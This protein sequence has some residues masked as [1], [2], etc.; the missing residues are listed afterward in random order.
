MSDRLH[1]LL[2]S[3]WYPSAE[4][5]VDGLFVRD[6]ARAASLFCDVTVLL[7]SGSA[8]DS[9]DAGL[10]V[11]R[12]LPDG[13]GILANF[14]R[15]LAI[16]ATVR[17][18]RQEGH[19]PDIIHGHVY[20]AAFVAVLVGRLQGLPVVVSEHHTDFVE[21]RLSRR[22]RIIARITFRSAKLVCP[23]SRALMQSM[24]ELE[25]NG[26]YSVVPNTVDVATFAAGMRLRPAAVDDP[27][28][29]N[30][31]GLSARRKGLLHL[32]EALRILL[33]RYPNACLKLAG[34]GPD[35]DELESAAEGLPVVFLGACSRDELVEL[36]READVLVMASTAETFGIAPLESLA[37]GL[38]VVATTAFP[39]ADLIAELGGQIVRPGDPSA[40]SEAITSV[41][42][43]RSFVRSDA[44]ARLSSKFGL[45]ATGRQWEAIYRSVVNQ[46]DGQSE[47]AS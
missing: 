30:V 9:S 33:S 47:P 13:A 41:V 28:L 46:T 11:L 44:A 15:L 8:S 16:A 43:G 7:R 24:A 4:A 22:D 18:L 35:R 29:L 2:V 6:Q 19:P 5:P 26:R 1:V 34:D 38:P 39:V 42:M 23:V 40:L 3:P 12:V 31:S 25:P 45:E 36:M 32:L 17:R 10:R 37:A 14:K 20:W 27:H 21:G